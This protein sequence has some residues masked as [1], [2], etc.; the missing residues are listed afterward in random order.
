MAKK[1]NNN[2]SNSGIS[3]G[4][5][6]TIRDILMGQQ[7][8]QNEE[9]FEIIEARIEKMEERFNNRI[10]TLENKLEEQH[11]TS[12]GDFTKRFEILETKLSNSQQSFNEK[13][14]LLRRKEREK[15]STLLAQL[16]QHLLE[17]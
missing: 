14:D 1:E 11:T 4:E 6:G 12:Q 17:E 15:L 7:I 8:S 3:S 9:R 16:S 13:I 2:I 10:K 5:I